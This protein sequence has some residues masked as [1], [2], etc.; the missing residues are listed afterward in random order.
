MAMGL[1]SDY[2]AR[3]A[4]ALEGS[5]TISE[6]HKALGLHRAMYLIPILDAALVVVLFAAALTVKRDYRRSHSLSEPEASATE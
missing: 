3:E 2:F 4:A 6:W 5:A 1:T